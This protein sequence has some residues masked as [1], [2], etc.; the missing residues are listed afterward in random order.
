[1]TL[2]PLRLSSPFRLREETLPP[3]SIVYLANECAVGMFS[4]RTSDWNTFAEDDG[5]KRS[6]LDMYEVTDPT[7]ADFFH[8]KIPGSFMGSPLWCG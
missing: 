5:C 4:R 1:M 2:L 3:S 8:N 7:V 6:R